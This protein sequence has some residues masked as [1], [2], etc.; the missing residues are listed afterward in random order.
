MSYRITALFVLVTTLLAE[1][2]RIES[3][4]ATVDD[5]KV[6]HEAFVPLVAFKCGYRNKFMNKSGEWQ[7]DPSSAA[8]CLEGK[9][10]ILKYCKRVGNFSNTF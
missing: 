10:D 4:S 8:V 1:A 7:D 2:A 9:L 5:R 6:K 3:I